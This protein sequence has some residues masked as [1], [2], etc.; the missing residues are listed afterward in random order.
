[1]SHVDSTTFAIELLPLYGLSVT[2]AV[3]STG[4]GF[5]TQGFFWDSAGVKRAGAWRSV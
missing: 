3:L 2:F 1:M 4:I 5:T